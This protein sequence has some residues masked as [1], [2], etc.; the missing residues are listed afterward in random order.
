MS[1]NGVGGGQPLH[2]MFC[3]LGVACSRKRVKVVPSRGPGLERRS[4][5]P[6]SKHGSAHHHLC[7]HLPLPAMLIQPSSVSDHSFNSL[8]GRE[9]ESDINND[10]KK[11]QQALGRTR[12]T[13]GEGCS[14]RNHSQA[15]GEGSQRQLPRR[16][17]LSGAITREGE[18][19][20]ILGTM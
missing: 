3:V 7:H 2:A 15:G 13:G 9:G 10:L 17:D 8:Q 20:I 19:T 6:E 16:G 4:L 1:H 18:E 12:R 14:M 11:E 5:L